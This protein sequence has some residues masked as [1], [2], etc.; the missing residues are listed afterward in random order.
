MCSP[1]FITGASIS[2][3]GRSVA[4]GISACVARGKKACG[5]VQR[6]WNNMQARRHRKNH[7]RE[8]A[9][10]Q[11]AASPIHMPLPPSAL[12]PARMPPPPEPTVGFLNSL[13]S[14]QTG[15]L[16]KPTAC[17]RPEDDPGKVLI[18]DLQRG[19]GHGMRLFINGQAVTSLA[20]SS[21]PASTPG[22]DILEAIFRLSGMSQYQ[23]VQNSCC[24]VLCQRGLGKPLGAVLV[25]YNHCGKIVPGH[26]VMSSD[27]N[28]PVC[29]NI[30]SDSH[31]TPSSW[32]ITVQQQQIFRCFQDDPPPPLYF[33]ATTK[34]QIDTQGTISNVST[35]WSEGRS[36]HSSHTSDSP[37]EIGSGG[38]GAAAAAGHADE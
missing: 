1:V 31:K 16:W 33:T 15:D 30:V 2:A 3:F 9:L 5:A 28:Y 19:F 7:L 26:R 36:P 6:T 22:T 37:I 8:R 23:L 35:V 27:P 14:K 24:E 34:L 4:S 17:L 25:A 18:S 13:T 21:I 12:S 20:D 32:T 11:P 10:R 29:I 38:A